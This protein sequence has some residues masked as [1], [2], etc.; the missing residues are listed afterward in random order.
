MIWN[1]D[2]SDFNCW[3]IN[4]GWEKYY[5]EDIGTG[6]IYQNWITPEGNIVQI[7]VSKDSKVTVIKRI[8]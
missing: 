8:S 6:N 4:S 3:A 7:T 5:T 1:E 2:F